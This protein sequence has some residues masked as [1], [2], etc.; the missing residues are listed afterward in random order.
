MHIVQFV[1]GRYCRLQ[2][3]GIQFFTFGICRTPQNPLILSAVFGFAAS[4]HLFI[5]APSLFFLLRLQLSCAPF[6]LLCLCAALLHDLSAVFL[7]ASFTFRFFSGNDIFYCCAV[8]LIIVFF[9]IVFILA[10]IA[11]LLRVFGQLTDQIRE[12]AK[13]SF[14][15]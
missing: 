14:S 1:P 12:I 11:H 8:F 10:L 6:L 5:F 3:H 9:F 13:K 15:G 7:A 4:A 2:C